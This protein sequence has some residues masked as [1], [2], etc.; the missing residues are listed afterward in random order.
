MTNYLLRQLAP[1]LA[2]AILGAALLFLAT[3][4]VR[5]TPAFVGAGA[6]IVEMAIGLGLLLVPVVGWSLTPAFA[7]A[8]FSVVGRMDADG[9]LTALDSAGVGRWRLAVAP[10]MATG[11]L[12]GLAAWIWLDAGPRAQAALHSMAG[13]LAGRAV[14]GK[15]QTGQFNELLPGI[16]VY[17]DHGQGNRFEGVMIEDRRHEGRS[18]QLIARS[19]KLRY[20][21]TS[22]H[23]GARLHDGRAFISGD[24]DAAPITL[25]FAQLDIGIDLFDELRRRLEFLPHLLAV[26]TSRLMEPPPTDIPVA[27]WGYALWRRVAGPCGLMVLALAA[28]ALALSGRW[29]HRGAAV[30]A[31][32]ALFLAYHLLCRLGEALTLSGVLT[33]PVA[34]LGP[35]VVV[36]AGASISVLVVGRPRPHRDR[37]GPVV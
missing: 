25:G 26:P 2:V 31:A 5:V 10:I 12:A 34:A 17:A 4:L 24:S 7:I 15:I 27:E 18:V 6:T 23:I 19:A 13:N 20:D 30:A 35:A 21:P 32:G 3:Q 8:I 1:W 28:T 14:A 22:R 37:N 29:R 9:E 16:T 36:L 11:A 33:P